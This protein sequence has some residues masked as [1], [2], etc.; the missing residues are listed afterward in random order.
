[1][2]A[3]KFPHQALE[4]VNVKLPLVSVADLHVTSP[5]RSTNRFLQAWVV[6]YDAD[7]KHVDAK[8][9][10]PPHQMIQRQVYNIVLADATA[11]IQVSAWDAQAVELFRVLQPL[12]DADELRGPVML[13]FQMFKVG[14]SRHPAFPRCSV[15]SSVGSSSFALS[16]DSLSRSCVVGALVDLSTPLL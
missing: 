16:L 7:I 8:A 14:S 1:M 9:V 2:T 15:L 4:D 11:P 5:H 3:R 6:D 10:E 12:R 13:D